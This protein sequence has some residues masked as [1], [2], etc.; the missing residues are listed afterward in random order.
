MSPPPSI[1]I[2]PCIQELTLSS[3]ER[4]RLVLVRCLLIKSNIKQS[5]VFINA[6]TRT[7]YLQSSTHD[8]QIN[9]QRPPIFIIYLKNT[10]RTFNQHSQVRQANRY[11]H[12]TRRTYYLTIIVRHVDGKRRRPNREH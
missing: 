2:R 11:Y 7:T 1:N 3:K 9:V 4:A 5:N 8:D 12:L 6:N 10:K